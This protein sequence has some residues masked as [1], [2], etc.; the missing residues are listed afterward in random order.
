M[1]L[2]ACQ[3]QVDIDRSIEAD[4]RTAREALTRL[5][6]RGPVPTVVEGDLPG[7]TATQRDQLVTGALA[8]GVRGLDVTFVAVPADRAPEQRVVVALERQPT[9][10]IE[11]LCSGGASRA[12]GGMAG[13]Q[14]IA[15]AFCDG[16][17]AVSA[18][19]GTVA[20]SG[21]RERE[22]LLWRTAD[23]LFPDDYEDSYGFGILPEWLGVGVGGSVGF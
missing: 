13:G 6:A 15:A 5:A 1:F 4:G 14:R 12:S 2:L 18:V 20:A 21:P 19:E 23:A 9:R 8:E 11:T 7:L 22:R 17:K 10:P 16:A 3:S